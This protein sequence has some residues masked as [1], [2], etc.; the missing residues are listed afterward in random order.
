ML[1]QPLSFVRRKPFAAFEGRNRQWLLKPA[2]DHF[3]FEKLAR[4]LLRAGDIGLDR[5]GRGSWR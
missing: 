5:P 1:F 4:C 3:F 2:R